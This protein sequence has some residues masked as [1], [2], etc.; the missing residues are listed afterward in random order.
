MVPKFS[1]HKEL[2]QDLEHFDLPNLVQSLDC[3]FGNI[4]RHAIIDGTTGK[5]HL[6][7]VADFLCESSQDNRGLPGCE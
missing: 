1:F 6:G 5:D 3:H 4:F 7:M 2:D